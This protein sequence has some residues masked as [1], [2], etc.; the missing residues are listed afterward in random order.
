MEDAQVTKAMQ[1]TTRHIRAKF[2][3]PER[4]FRIIILP[5]ISGFL[6]HQFRFRP[7]PPHTEQRDHDP[8]HRFASAQLPNK[9]PETNHEHPV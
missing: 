1:T 2:E 3:A 9:T 6:A 8:S 7:H 5:Y 4:E